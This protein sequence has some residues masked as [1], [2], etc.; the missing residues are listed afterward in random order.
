MLKGLQWRSL[1][2]LVLVLVMLA[3][4]RWVP[5]AGIAA[6]VA[7]ITVLTMLEFFLLLGKAGLPDY[8]FVG[9]AG[10]GV[11]TLVAAGLSLRV[12]DSASAELAL[13][14][15][16]GLMALILLRMLANRQTG[17]PLM[18]AATTCLGVLYIAVPFVFFDLLMFAW[19]D[20]TA[21]SRLGPTGF[22]LMC[23]LVLVVKMGDSA[24]Y[25]VGTLWGRHKMISRISPGKTWEG[26]WGGL[27]AGVLCSV[28]FQRMS[29][30]KLGLLSWSVADALSLGL[31][32]GLAGVAGDLVESQC[33]RSVGAK[34]SGGLIPGI[35]GLLDLMDS[36][37]LAAPVLY[38]YTR[39]ALVR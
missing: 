29:G 20:C 36:L 38:V 17:S 10:G 9:A 13:W 15:G 32:L 18:A 7:T 30:G 22:V 24:A 16:A 6:V 33:K 28:L 39:C 31:L 35:G 2:T 3:G 14:G 26:F 21:G 5:C 12:L 37:L 19:P 1:S 8:P 34:D 11:M 23:Y 4:L 27:A 25:A